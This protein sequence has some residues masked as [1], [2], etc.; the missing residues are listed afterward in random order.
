[1]MFN[2]KLFHRL[3]FKLWSAKGNYHWIK[4]YRRRGEG[5]EPLTSTSRPKDQIIPQ[6]QR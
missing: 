6:Q 3:K 1:M 4:N 2:A 5:K